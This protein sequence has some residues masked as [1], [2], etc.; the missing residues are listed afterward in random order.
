MAQVALE[1]PA[2]RGRSAGWRSV[3]DR[4]LAAPAAA[5]RLA[6]RF[7]LDRVLAVLAVLALPGGIAAILLGWSGAARTPFLFEQIPY[8]IS[9]GLLGVGLLTAGGALYL[10]SWIV[11]SSQLARERE[12]ALRAV[13]EDVRDEL[14]DANR[15]AAAGV[16]APSVLPG[17]IASAATAV[18]A[19]SATT[20]I[21]VVTAFVATP[22]GSMFHRSACHVVAGRDDV[23]L[24]T[25]A[26]GRRP[27]GM[28]E[29][30][31]G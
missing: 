4:V 1:R 5:V 21:P 7:P 2:T 6:Q 16:G 11:R 10:G 8:L 18:P 15:R 30:L 3:R 14:R 28:C 23:V 27:C 31:A 26:D 12:D 25:P 19:T 17:P 9:G 20:E 24:V 13:L 22:S 29:P